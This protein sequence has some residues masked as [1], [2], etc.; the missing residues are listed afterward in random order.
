MNNTQTQSPIILM[1]DF[2]TRDAYVG[3]MKGVMLRLCPGVPFIDL[4]HEIAPQDVRQ[5]AYVLW[6][7][8]RYF[9]KGSVFLAVVDPGVG[10]S[11]RA[12]AVEA[13]P[14]KFVGPDNGIFQDV[15]GTIGEWRAV[16]ID[17]ANAVPEG[18]TA[19]FHGRDLFAPTAARL[20]AGQP[21]ESLGTP[22]TD[23]VTMRAAR[24]EITDTTIEGEVLTIDHFGNVVSSIGTCQWQ[25]DGSLQLTPRLRPDLPTVQFDPKRARVTITR[26]HF[27]G[28]ARTYTEVEAG[29]ALALI[30]SA[31]QLEIAVNQGSARDQLDLLVGNR[32]TIHLD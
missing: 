4:T 30:N 16:A 22:V 6:S 24:L 5:A 32:V 19:T 15:L 26:H 7:A 14:F 25:D 1:T 21:L 2:G 29:K 28:I 23:L 20:A 27:S 17:P 10:S 18:L 11:R 3:M 9:P 8:Y 13:G 31:G 12:I